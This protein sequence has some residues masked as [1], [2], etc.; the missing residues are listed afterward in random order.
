MNILKLIQNVFF[1]LKAAAMNPFRRIIKRMKQIFNVNMLSAKLLQPLNKKIKQIFNVKPKSKEDYVS[2]GIFWISRKLIYFII[3]AACAGVFIFFTTFAKPV[4]DTVTATNLITTVY[5]DYDDLALTEFSGKANI[6]AANGEVVYTGDVA[7]GVCT[8]SGTLWNQDGMMVYKGD[9]KNNDFSGSGTL[10]YPDKKVLY[11]GNFEN[12]NF[13]GLGVSYYQDGTVEYEGE[14]EN[15]V[16]SGEGSKYDQEGNV[17]YTGL[18]ENGKYNGLGTLYYENGTKKYEGEFSLG[19]QQG[20]GTLYSVTG[21]QLFK[22]SFVRNQIQYES[23]L[24]VTMADILS[25]CDEIPKVYFSRNSTCFLF[26]GLGI[27]VNAN[28]ITTMRK[29]DSDTDQG[30][31]WYLPGEDLETELLTEN[32]EDTV[33]VDFPDNLSSGEDGE[34]SEDGEDAEG[35]TGSG[36]DAGGGSEDGEKTGS[37]NQEGADGDSSADEEDSGIDLPVIST[38]GRYSVYYYLD[39]DAWVEEASLDYSKIMATSLV[40][41]NEDFYTG[42]LKDE[43]IT[44]RNG[45]ADLLECVAIDRLRLEEPTLF[46]NITF[47]QAA[48]TNK[49]IQISGINLAQAIY[50]EEYEV[51]NV[52]YKLC[53]ELDDYEN[54]RFVTLQTY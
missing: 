18:F 50:A 13:S 48:V 2:L 11:K 36:E 24:N 51:D 33:A 17:V 29:K 16:Y 47:T 27:A 5:F 37:G 6:R 8:G 30:N 23:L 46:S 20:N 43:T 1:R 41:F 9:F 44:Y 52:R 28:C 10:Y 26:E 54:C 25:M 40:V 34:G 31:G 49:H 38:S 21:K 39:T 4:E 32:E 7:A 45:E 3:F 15:G 14:F 42:F 12:N 22:G 19:N 53:Y 35:G